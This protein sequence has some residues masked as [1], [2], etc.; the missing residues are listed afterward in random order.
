VLPLTPLEIE[1]AKQIAQRLLV[2]YRQRAILF[3][4]NTRDLR[5]IQQVAEIGYCALQNEPPTAIALPLLRTLDKLSSRSTARK[6]LSI[7]SLYR[8]RGSGYAVG[9]HTVGMAVDIAAYQGHTIDMGNPHEAVEGVLAIVKA[10][11]PRPYRLGLPRANVPQPRAFYPPPPRPKEAVFFPAP[12]PFVV[13]FL[14]IVP[15]RL[16][17]GRLV[18]TRH[19]EI[20]P[21]V[22]AWENEHS[23]PLE[24]IG[25]PRVKHVLQEAAL[26]GVNCHLLFPDA[27]NHLHLDVKPL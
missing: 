8:P 25:S 10:L 13:P 9:L 20:R 3:V 2:R 18:K 7:L 4:N 19:G 23:A 27:T 12:L 17:N 14:N 26:R 6:P 24:E 22:L 11:D 1:E 21:L 5:E 15:P 16:E